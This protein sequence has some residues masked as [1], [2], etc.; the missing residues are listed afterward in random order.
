MAFGAREYSI[1]IILMTTVSHLFPRQSESCLLPQ[2][3]SGTA[4]RLGPSLQ[5]SVSPSLSKSPLTNN[6]FFHTIDPKLEVGSVWW[7]FSTKA[8]YRSVYVFSSI[9]VQV[10]VSNSRACVYDLLYVR[11][12]LRM[13]VYVWLYRYV[14]ICVCTSVRVLLMKPCVHFKIYS[15]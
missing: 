11:K 9:F 13:Y 2:K 10:C 1:S 6:T 4:R 8:W 5:V 14:S 7:T 15:F 12:F 3:H